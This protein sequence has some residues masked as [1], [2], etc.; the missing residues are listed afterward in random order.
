MNRNESS[1]PRGSW[2]GPLFHGWIG[3]ILLGVFA[4][5]DGAHGVTPPGA[6]AGRS[7]V[8]VR[9]IK[10]T[11][12]DIVR[13]VVLPGNVR[14]DL[15]VTLYAKVT[16]FLKEITKDR[17]DRV[18]T[19]ELIAT[20][21]IPE[22]LAEIDH[23]RASNAL[24]E[25]TFKRL[26]AIRKVEKTAVTDQDLDIARAK[27]D[28]SLATLKKLETLQSYT[29]IRAPF[30][31]AITERF[32][33]PGA[34][35]QQGKIVSMVDI[36]KVRVLVDIPEAEVRAAQVGTP[37]EI[38]FDAL[39]GKSFQATVS[40]TAGSLDST[41]RTMR[42][43]IDVS[44]PGLVIYPGMFGRVSLEVDPHPA[45]LVL[46]TEAVTLQQDKAFVFVDSEGKAK[47]I[48]VQLG[49]E[50]G[51]RWEI[52]KGLSGNEAI[53]VSQGKALVEGNTFHP[54]ALNPPPPTRTA[55]GGDR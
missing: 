18:K 24:D 4:G 20:L 42:V 46:P 16:G 17:G 27:R 32:V 40:R 38:Q 34:F 6:E 2:P 55:G 44:N 13:K 26:E 15:E 10:P 1:A 5:C 37:A 30:S 11:R 43:E 31:G 7:S 48:P 23:A 36:S 35:I 50:D 22:M 45:A 3:A 47:K 51:G 49:I 39:P 41:L 12:Q 9:I 29:E 28:M 14:A 54:V 21:E 25:S 19:G 8:E 33:D 52:L 53:L